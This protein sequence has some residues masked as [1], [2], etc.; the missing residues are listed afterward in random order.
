VP[1]HNTLC[2][3]HRTLVKPGVVEDML[4]V[5]VQTAR[6]LERAAK[7]NY[8]GKVDRSSIASSCRR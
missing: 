6:K 5:S 3:A 2:R 7:K 8:A 4:D 1:N